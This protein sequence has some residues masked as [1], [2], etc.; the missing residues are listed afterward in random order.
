MSSATQIMR[1]VVGG[2]AALTDKQAAST[3]EV[4][5]FETEILSFGSLLPTL[6]NS[7]RNQRGV[8]DALCNF[9]VFDLE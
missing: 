4:G 9:H 6:R 1:H 3:S 5:H 8:H 7:G 2:R